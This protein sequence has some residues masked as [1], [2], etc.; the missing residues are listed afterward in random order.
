MNGKPSEWCEAVKKTLINKGMSARQLAEETGYS[1]ST[2]S[3]V[4]NG[5]YTRGGR[6]EIEKKIDSVL[7]AEAVPKLPQWYGDVKNAMRDK[8][9]SVRQLAEETGYAISTVSQTINGRYS[10]RNYQAIAGRINSVLGTKGLP[11]RFCAPSDEW[12][13]SVKIGLIRKNMSVS[14]L[15]EASGVTRDKMSHVINGRM[16][17]QQVV[18]TVS[19]LLDIAL[20]E[21]SSGMSKL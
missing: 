8:G 2:I 3:M 16:M 18:N 14:Q 17:D 4:L 12:C 19:R 11:E 9:M 1:Y 10:R 13:Q 5:R 15:A 20:P 21:S 7:C 6:V